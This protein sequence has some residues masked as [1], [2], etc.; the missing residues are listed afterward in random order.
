MI[1]SAK[2]LASVLLEMQKE[3]ESSDVLV[4]KISEFLRKKRKLFLLPDVLQ[5]L[6]SL[7]QK[8]SS[9]LSIR[10]ISAFPIENREE[11]EE[12]AKTLFAAEK[13]DFTYL[14]QPDLQGGV[15]IETDEKKWDGSVKKTLQALKNVL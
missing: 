1:F 5:S 10:I 2:Q 15:I 13:Y 11:V 9:S 14:I 12:K 8:E 6:S 3:G 4:K 7:E